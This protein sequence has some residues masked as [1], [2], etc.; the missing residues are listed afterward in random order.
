[1]TVLPLPRPNTLASF[2]NVA[3]RQMYTRAFEAA[4]SGAWSTLN[5][6]KRA[7]A[8]PVLEDVLN[9]IRH[10]HPQSN[11]TFHEIARFSL[12]HPDWPKRS[13]LLAQ[14]EKAMGDK[15]LPGDVIRWFDKTPPRTVDGH[16]RLIR[17]LRAEGRTQEMKAAIRKAWRTA[18]FTRKQERVFL[19]DY[20]Y[21]LEP[22]DHWRRLDRL[23]WQAGHREATRMLL[24]VTKGQRR[25]AEAR[26]GLRRAAGNVDT[27]I[28][29]VPAALSDDPGLLY[30]R[31]RWRHRKG[32]EA[33]ARELFW[34]IP[35]HDDHERL[36]W[37]ERSIQIRNAL[38]E[39]AHDDAYLLA[40]THNQ[41]KGAP[42]ADAEW[43]AGWVALR[44]AKKPEEALHAF[45]NLFRNVSTPISRARAAYW[46]GR[47][48][49]AV[50]DKPLADAW[51]IEGAR[52]TTTFYGQLSAAKRPGGDLR[53]PK[54]PTAAKGTDTFEDW[55]LG[56]AATALIK[57]GQRELARDFLLHMA[58]VA[59]SGEAAARVGRLAT[60]FGYTDLGV[61]A[62]RRAARN[63]HILIEIGYPLRPFERADGLEDALALA[64]I[65]QE[66]AFDT[67]AKSRVG[68]RGLM[69]LMP[70]TAKQVAKQVG[71]RYAR[72]KLTEDPDYNVRLG[73]R[74]LKDLIEQFDGSYVLAIAAYNAGPGRAK[75]WARQYGDPR[76]PSV[77]V[78]DWIERIP[79]N[80]TRNYVQ[81]VLEGL[82]VYR[83]RL[84]E[85]IATSSR[86]GG[87]SPR[88]VWCVTKCGVQIDALQAFAPPTR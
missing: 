66:S 82:Q 85:Q 64:I 28:R 10:T 8:D 23:L 77:D 83:L 88:D 53:L 51:Y 2:E 33:A 76:D 40:T 21:A 30:E 79:F 69:Q 47:A 52:Y 74:Y 22:G 12:R 43:H 42:F 34:R 29:R 38:D 31:I 1:M 3:L 87:P 4:R 50:G 11:S 18:S 44:F 35:S 32:K 39:K 26:I 65:R 27:L 67:D 19:T 71:L 84:G 73:R 75:R 45:V 62:A 15:L 78:V 36:W 72:A 14:A 61:H 68:A 25:L 46:A 81:R 13:R 48:A 20:G 59:D 9:W 54:D 70:A 63:G 16:T 49:E 86:S 17:A 41:V 5:R 60:G 56:E 6:I 55:S 80:E 7:D 58:R 37:R 24:R 57:A